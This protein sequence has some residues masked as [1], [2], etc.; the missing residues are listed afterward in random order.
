MTRVASI[1]L[2]A[3]GCFLFSL[4]RG[5]LAAERPNI[6]F[7]FADDWGRYASIYAEVDGEGTANDLLSTPHFDRVAR[8]GV[9]FTHAFVNAPSCTPCRSALL[10][11]QDFFRTGRAAI[12]QGARWDASIPAFPLLLRDGGYHIGKVHKVWSP[13]RPNDAPFGEDEYE[14]GLEGPNFNRFSQV[15]TDK[16]QG[17]LS[18]DE[19]KREMLAVVREEFEAFLDAG[20]AEAP[21]LYWFGPTNVH[22]KWIQGSGRA[23]WGLDP[24]QLEGK[25]PAFLPDVP[26]VRQDFADYLGEAMAFDAAL[27]VLVDVLE[28]R[29]E[30]E[31]T[32]VMVSGDHGAPGFPRGKCNLYDF[33]VRVPLAARWGGGEIPAGRVVEDFVDLKDLAPTLLEAGGVDVPEVMN[34]RSALDLLRSEES[35]V[36]DGTRD[37]V[38][39]GRERHV[40]EAREGNKPYPQR[41][42]RTRDH[43]YIIN[44]EP[45]RWPMG[46]PGSVAEGETPA[47]DALENDTFVCFG[48]LDASPTKA[49]MV[50]RR[51]D[52]EWADEYELG[53]GKR[54][55]HELY[56][57]ADD[58]DQVVNRAGDPELAEIERGLRER[59]LSYLKEAGDP[60]VTEDSVPYERPP[61]TDER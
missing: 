37:H 40:A 12:L 26:M 43:L 61:F 35:G 55:R 49:W 39:T 45:D 38:I 59:L 2:A 44:F 6:L 57:L 16:V 24:D 19:A 53:F 30:L 9:L 10:S 31:N 23:L 11:G 47:W 36:V 20:E 13:G 22:R 33:G 28:E 60:R 41:A 42:I 4:P 58:P 17:G 14:F 21:F 3:A 1:L 7:A 48:D 52:P 32:L 27:G 56:V 51:E 46:D 15:A 18:V 34:G 54:P 25:L 5:G 50:E 8:E 29:G